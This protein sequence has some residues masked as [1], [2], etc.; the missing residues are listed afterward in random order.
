MAV[1][2]G[3]TYRRNPNVY[4]E[5]MGITGDCKELAAVC[6]GISMPSEDIPSNSPAVKNDVA[7]RAWESSKAQEDSKLRAKAAVQ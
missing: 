3:A 5:P 4:I 1:R 7:E 6:L 2:Q